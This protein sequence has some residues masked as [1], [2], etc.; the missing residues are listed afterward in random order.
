MKHSHVGMILVAQT[1]FALLSYY[2][3]QHAKRLHLQTLTR[4][5][6]N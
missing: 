2:Y 5:R 4:L 1:N 6:Y 3:A